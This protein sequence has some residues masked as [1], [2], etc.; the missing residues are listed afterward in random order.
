MIFSVPRYRRLSED[1][2]ARLN[3]DDPRNPTRRLQSALLNILL[4]AGL[5]GV[6]LYGRSVVLSA[7]NEPKSALEAVVGK[8]RPTN[9]SHFQ[10]AFTSEGQFV[11]SWKE[12][13]V[14]TARYS[15]H[16]GDK[17]VIV[18][19]DFRKLDE[20]VEQGAIPEDGMCWFGVSW[21]K[22]K[23]SITYAFDWESERIRPGAGWRI[24]DER[25]ALPFAFLERIE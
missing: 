14:A 6:P 4:L 7:M 18:L 9:G 1:D 12:T 22:G 16:E 3:K 21:G 17:H 2:L 11:L 13:V 15:S 19:S 20:R 25:L 8:W 5:W 23:L 24:G 10:I